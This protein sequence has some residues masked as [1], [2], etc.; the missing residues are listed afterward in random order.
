MP[1]SYAAAVMPGPNKA[2]EVREFT[3]PEIEPGAALLATMYSE[4]CGTDVH[5]HHG[6]LAGVP[7][8]IIPGHVSVG[9]VDKMNGRLTT[10]S[11]DPVREGDVVT[12]LD[13]HEVCNHCY[14]CL[15]AG[16]PN[17]CPSRKVYGITYS[18]NDGLLG[19][20]SQA[21]YM[22]PGVK[23]LHLPPE[24]G[25][26]TFIGGGCGLVTALHAVDLAAIRLG[27]S[28]AVMGVGPVG[29]SA[30]ALASLSGAGEVVA[31]DAVQDRLDYALRMGATRTVTLKTPRKERLS[32]VHGFTRGRGVDVVIEASGHPDAVSEALDIVRD[33]GRVVVCGHYTDN[34][35]VEIHPHWQINRKHVELR[36]CW[37]SRY[38]H[39]HRCVEIAV[40]NGTVPWAEMVTRRYAL[41][42]AAEALASI[43]RRDAVKAIVTPN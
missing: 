10:V 15:V 40:R 7:Y 28:V 35:S 41:K 14:H 29:Q 43:E 32:Q 31:V 33:G 20:W 4:V 3:A 11:G 23:M 6:K 26:E 37:G 13:V 12:F 34:G 21:I 17:R 16:Q 19:G 24:L 39:F 36:G 5:L 2:V 8:P 25:P 22:K 1:K 27:E 9:R 30:V 42:S 38:E 18:A